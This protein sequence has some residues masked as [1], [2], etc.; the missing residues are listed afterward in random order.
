MFFPL[1]FALFR[2]GGGGGGG[3][4]G[5]ARNGGSQDKDPIKE[6]AELN[7][8]LAWDSYLTN[9]EKLEND[10]RGAKSAGIMDTASKQMN[11]MQS[12]GKALN[13]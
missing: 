4:E 7:K 10:A 1:L 13:Y 9:K 12:A 5:N 8:K 2:A 6:Q 11:A 3:A